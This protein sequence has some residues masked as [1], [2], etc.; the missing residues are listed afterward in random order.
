MCQFLLSSLPFNT[1]EIITSLRD[2]VS[3][4]QT[5]LIR[6]DIENKAYHF[7]KNLQSDI[8][9]LTV[10]ITDI[11]HNL[12]AKAI[13]ELKVKIK[14]F[15]RVKDISEFFRPFMSSVVLKK[16]IEKIRSGVSIKGI[17][18]QFE[19][20]VSDPNILMKDKTAS[21]KRLFEE[22]YY[23]IHNEKTKLK[24]NKVTLKDNINKLGAIFMLSEAY[25]DSNMSEVEFLADLFAKPIGLKK[26]S[27]NLIHCKLHQLLESII[28]RLEKDS[29]ERFALFRIL[30][31]LDFH[32]SDVKWIK[33]FQ[34]ILCQVKT[35]CVHCEKAGKN[36]TVHLLFPKLKFLKKLLIDINLNSHKLHSD[37]SFAYNVESFVVIE[38]AILDILSI[39][40]AQLTRNPFYLDS[41]YSLHIG[42]NLR[43]HLAHEN[44][45]VNIVS[46]VPMQLLLNAKK[47]ISEN[48]DN[49][50]GNIQQVEESIREGADI[51]G[52]NLHNT[53][54]LHFSAK[55]PR[56]NAI[57][58]VFEHGLGINSK[59]NNDQTALHVA[60]K[61]N[62]L[63]TVKHLIEVK[64]VPLN[65]R[66]VNGK[67]AL[68]IAVGND[69][70]EVVEYLL[71]NGANTLI[72]D[73]VGF[74]PLN[75][76]IRLKFVDVAKVLLEKE[77]SAD[78]N[79]SI[80]GYTSLHFAAEVG[81]LI[82]VNILIEKKPDVNFKTEFGETPLILAVARG[83]LEV[84]RALLL[85]KAEIN[86]KNV[87]GST[88]LHRA[89]AEGHEEI[90][91]LLLDHEANVNAFDNDCVSPLHCSAQ[92]G[93]ANVMKLL[94]NKNAD[95]NI[96][97]NLGS[98]PLHYAAENVHDVVVNMLLVH[99]ALVDCVDIAKRTALHYSAEWGHQNIAN[100]L[101]EKGAD[102]DKKDDAGLT[103]LHLAADR[104]H[105]HVA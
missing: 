8:S 83:H 57:I 101:I 75:T 90:V 26:S 98:T 21:E 67:T 32:V 29:E 97:T 46:D 40:D 50:N 89:S 13:D 9:K 49:K 17:V 77:T 37:N 105:C 45:L 85:K 11:L 81:G 16:E 91:K 28:S 19:E 79:L 4:S 27:M 59:D 80:C 93:H 69:C 6:S 82:L 42:K 103:P 51:F 95:V 64:H 47:I 58:F 88:P 31:L 30:F 99:K 1:R 24:T 94:L 14:S 102:M 39:S 34:G 44:A 35:K 48:W 74:L 70:R 38:M 73:E 92:G 10:T 71:R 3:H 54:C 5:L 56:E 61:F 23:M 53:S 76:A 22:I 68:H 55:A 12:K 100:I 18:E 33:E 25:E 86:A 41:G 7:F 66:D 43:N 36:S 15:K 60:A 52:K 20:L 104:G 65:D 87:F 96:Q 72:K 78:A 62:R 63:K 84:V 2:S